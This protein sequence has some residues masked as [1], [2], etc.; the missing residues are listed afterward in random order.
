MTADEVMFFRAMPGALPL[1]ETLRGKVL[2]EC[3]DT[4]LNVH[5]SQI[6]FRAHYGYAFVSLRRMKGCPKVFLIVPF[7][8]STVWT[9]RASPQLRNRI[10]TAGRIMSSCRRKSSW[11]MN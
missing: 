2:A 5:K 6:T 10:P 9:H 11:M 4:T 8:L 7:G 3:P 1:Y